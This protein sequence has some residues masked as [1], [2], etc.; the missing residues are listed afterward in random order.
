MHAYFL[1]KARKIIEKFETNYQKKNPEAIKILK[2]EIENE[3]DK[4]KH[5]IRDL[6]EFRHPE[7]KL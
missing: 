3:R 4:I 1:F 2:K 6:I 7:V 5:I